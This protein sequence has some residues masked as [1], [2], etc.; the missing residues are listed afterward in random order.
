MTKVLLLPFLQMPSGHHQAADA[1][2]AYIRDLDN[3]AVIKKVDIFK[4]TSRLAEQ[5]TT[6]LYLKAIRMAPA[7]YSRIYQYN[8]CTPKDAGRRFFLYEGFFLK[9]MKRLLQEENPDL[10]VCTHC[11]PSYLL[12]RLKMIGMLRVP[13]V[14]A[15]TDY[16]I[17]NVWGVSDI[18]LHLT[19]SHAMRDELMHKGVSS[20]RVAVTGIPVHPEMTR[21]N[22]G[23]ERAGTPFQVLVSGGHLGVGPVEELFDAASLSGRITYVILCGKNKG[24]YERIAGMGSPFLQPIPYVSLRSEMNRIYNQADLVLS[25]PGGVTISECLRKQVPLCL[26]KALP[27]QEEKNREY[28]LGERLA[29]EMKPGA[30]EEQLLRFLEDEAER[31]AMEVRLGR[32]SNE[33]ES[34]TEVLKKVLFVR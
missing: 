20:E 10:I 2:S 22:D 28:L 7:I 25:K 15:Y 13:V 19:P 16:F 12:N 6:S 30:M 24:L 31:E 34:V 23:G 9:S 8:A 4:Y 11:L 18:D 5:F 29:I 27:G 32:Y 33:L 17:N 14:N 21:E 26:L 3:Q 1:V